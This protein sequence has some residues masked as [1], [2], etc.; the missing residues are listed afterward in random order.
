MGCSQ[1]T[2]LKQLSHKFD[3]LYSREDITWI[4]EGDSVPHEQWS[5]LP[6]GFGGESEFYRALAKAMRKLG[7]T[8]WGF[9]PGLI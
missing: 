1:K 2:T 4:G 3:V 8:G 6:K 9:V 5:T 7:T